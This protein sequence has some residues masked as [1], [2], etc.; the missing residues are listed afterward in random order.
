MYTPTSRLLLQR[1]PDN[2]SVQKCQTLCVRQS[3]SCLLV[4]NLISLKPKICPT[5]TETDKMHVWMNPPSPPPPLP[6]PPPSLSASHSVYLITT[7]EH[8]LFLLLRPVKL[9][10]RLWSLEYDTQRTDGC[11]IYAYIMYTIRPLITRIW[12]LTDGGHTY[13]YIYNY[14]H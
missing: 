2:K 9:L 3:A 10:E 6:R 1:E 12:Y 13:I 14:V 5:R 8:K 4:T 11:H 7:T